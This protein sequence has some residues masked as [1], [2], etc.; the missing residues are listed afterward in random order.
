LP[1][2]LSIGKNENLLVPDDWMTLFS[3]PVTE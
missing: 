1:G 2:P 3:S